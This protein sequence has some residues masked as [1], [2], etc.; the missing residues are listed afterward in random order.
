MSLELSYYPGC[1]LHGTAWELDNSV[2]TVC[3]ALGIKLVELPDWN[4]CGASSAHT[5]DEYL[6]VALPAR[7]LLIAAREEKDVMVPCIA[8]FQRLRNAQQKLEKDPNMVEG[9]TYNGSPKLMTFLKLMSQPEIIEKI[10]E[11]MEKSLEGI[12]AVCYY[13]CLTTRPPK[14]TGEKNFENPME[15]DILME[16]LGA[17]CLDWPYKTDCCGA[18]LGLG[19]IDILHKLTGKVLNMAKKVG[20]DC[21]ITGCPM[22]HMSLDARQKEIQK[23]TGLDVSIPVFYFSELIG[24]VLGCKETKKWWRKHFQNP[25]ILLKEKELI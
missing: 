1:S 25:K 21:V 9:I 6:T 11:N 3:R 14:V 18:S 15:M 7:N 4:C 22:C 8:C 2:Q 24:L 13:G 23:A 17:E 5:L 19:R 10:K 12:K 16:E 20:A